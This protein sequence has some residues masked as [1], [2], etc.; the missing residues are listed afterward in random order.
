[1]IEAGGQVS[2][3]HLSGEYFAKRVTRYEVGSF[4]ENENGGVN[5]I[6]RPCDADAVGIRVEW[7]AAC[8]AGERRPV[9][10]DRTAA[11][12][13]DRDYRQRSYLFYARQAIML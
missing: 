5:P 8:G 7:R 6:L 2:R 3:F 12:R 13:P 9:S 1:M 11:T 4:Y 10:R